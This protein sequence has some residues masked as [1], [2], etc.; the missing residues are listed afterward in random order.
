[1]GPGSGGQ[2]HPSIGSPL[3]RRADNIPMSASSLSGHGRSAPAKAFDATARFVVHGLE[4]HREAHHLACGYGLHQC[5]GQI[6]ARLQLQM[7]VSTVLERIPTMWLAVPVGEVP[8]RHDLF[9]YGVHQ[10]RVAW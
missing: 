9:L 7:V 1:V 10:L 2:A 4:S 5:I 3:L 8:F 6:L